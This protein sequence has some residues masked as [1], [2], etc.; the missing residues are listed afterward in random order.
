MAWVVVGRGRAA[1]C[2][3]ESAAPQAFVRVAR[4]ARRLLR[5]TRVRRGQQILF[6]APADAPGSGAGPTPA[7]RPRLRRRARA[8]PG[9]PAPRG[10]APHPR[11]A[12]PH[13]APHAALPGPPRGTC[14]RTLMRCPSQGPGPA[15]GPARPLH[16]FSCSKYMGA[17]RRLAVALADAAPH[18]DWRGPCRLAAGSSRPPARAPHRPPTRA[19][20]HEP[21]R[22]GRAASGLAARSCRG[23]GWG[24]AMGLGARGPGPPGGRL[25]SRIGGGRARC[26]GAANGE[27]DERGRKPSGGRNG[28]C[29][30]GPGRRGGVRWLAGTGRAC[31]RACAGPGLSCISLSPQNGTYLTQT[32]TDFPVQIFPAEFRVT[33]RLVSNPKDDFSHTHL[34]ALLSNNNKRQASCVGDGMTFHR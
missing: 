20:A 32:S 31:G 11:P 34:L 3:G 29:C 18:L 22:L 9:G 25:V 30:R 33:R 13:P 6:L 14:Q 8:G 7:R 15:P 17:T 27:G 16:C 12:P 4:A 1:R 19:G 28:Q 23:G 21:T 5:V 24:P 26:G 10:A 2:G